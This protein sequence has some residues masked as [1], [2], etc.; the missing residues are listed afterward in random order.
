MSEVIK[1]PTKTPQSSQQWWDTV[2]K[3]REAFEKWLQQQYAG[4]TMAA[5]RISELANRF[6]SPNTVAD[7]LLNRIISDELKH[8]AWIGKILTQYVPG[9]SKDVLKESGRYWKEVEIEALVVDTF[10]YTCAVA[11]H[12][13]S[14]RLERIKVIAADDEF[15]SVNP[16]IQKVFKAILIDENFHAEAFALMAGPEALAQAERFHH[17]GMAAIGLTI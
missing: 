4:E 1:F 5:K 11:A 2:K 9:V 6:T 16:Y 15:G 10:E 13:E 8:A 12:A 3:D 17:K 7:F 14:M